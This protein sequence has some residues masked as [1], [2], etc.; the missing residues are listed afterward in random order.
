MAKKPTILCSLL[1]FEGLASHGA[2][3]KNRYRAHVQRTSEH[4]L[5]G[6][7]KKGSVTVTSLIVRIDFEHKMIET[8]NSVYDYSGE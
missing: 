7:D 4:P 1:F 5:L 3:Y 2:E 8:L 6:K